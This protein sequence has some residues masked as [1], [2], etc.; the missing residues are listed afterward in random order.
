M[1]SILNAHQILNYSY[2]SLAHI[3]FEH[4]LMPFALLILFYV[5]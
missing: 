2:E 1:V 4:L 3:L 5:I